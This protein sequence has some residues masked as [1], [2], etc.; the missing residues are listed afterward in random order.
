M[1]SPFG[2]KVPAGG[3]IESNYAAEVA[4]ELIAGNE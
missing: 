2:K 4:P 3:T 1:D